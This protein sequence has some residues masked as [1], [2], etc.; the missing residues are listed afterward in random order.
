MSALKIAFVA[1]GKSIHTARWANA[2]AERGHSVTVYSCAGDTPQN[3][4]MFLEGVKIVELKYKAPL[5]YYLNARSLKKLIRNGNFDVVNVHYASGYGTLGRRAKLK[6]AL[7][8]IWGSDVYDF[9][10]RSSFNMR[11]VKKNLAYYNRLASTSNCM[12][13]QAQ[14]IVDREFE[15]TPFGVD[16]SRFMPIDGKKQEGKFIFGTVKTLSPTYGICDSVNAFIKLYN[17]LISEDCAELADSLY[18][19]IYG[20][21]EQQ[22]EIQK[23]IDDS[24]MSERIKLCGF[25]ENSKL[26]QIYNRF[27]AACYAS[28]KESFGVAVVEAMACGVPVCATDADGFAEVVEEGVSGLLSPKGDP[29]ALAENMYKLLTDGA[30]CKKM[31]EAG[32]ERVKKLYEWNANVDKMESIYKRMI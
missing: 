32:V 23:L 14:R 5:G 25:V 22:E 4:T 10:Y 31:G 20:R 12:A 18:Y 1:S 6:N 16:T 13:R 30:L 28:I 19:E 3:N 11:T 24:G 15:I 2:M 17:R 9:P 27:N 26:P 29:S 7:L 8:N 21:G